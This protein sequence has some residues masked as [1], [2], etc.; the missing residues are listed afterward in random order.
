MRSQTTAR[1][2]CWGGI[3]AFLL[4]GECLWAQQREPFL[5]LPFENGAQ[6]V[7]YHWVGEAFSLLLSELLEAA[8]EEVISTEDRQ[9]LYAQLQLPEG[10]VLTRASALK[11]AERLGAS[12]L[13]VGTY[14]VT[15]SRG[16]ER[17]AV[18][19]RVIHVREARMVTN[20][21]TLGAPLQELSSLM[22]T[23]AGEVRGARLSGSH[24][25]LAHLVTA[26]PVAALEYYVKAQMATDPQVKMRLLQRAERQGASAYPPLL[27]ELG[28]AHLDHGQYAE[29]APYFRRL[30]PESHL[31]KE[32]QFYLGICALRQK[33][34]ARAQQIYQ[35]LARLW[36]RPEVWNN[37][38]VVELERGQVDAALRD[39]LR[40]LEHTDSDPDVL[41]N[42]G[43]ALWR[44]GDFEGAV[45]PLQ[46][47]VRRQPTDAE[48]QY[49]LGRSLRQLGR[50]EEA[51]KA[52]AVARQSLPALAEWEKAAVPPLLPRLKMR[53]SRRAEGGPSSSARAHPVAA[54][55][56]AQ[57]LIE[58]GRVEEALAA[59]D[60]L[61]KRAPDLAEAHLLKARV[62]VQRG[63]WREALDAAQA[64]AFWDPQLVAAH[65][66]IARIYLSVGERERARASIRKALALD[67]NNPEGRELAQSMEKAQGKP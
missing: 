25:E 64:A 32:A 9:A 45:K 26:L 43:Y 44:R 29:A 40:A 4:L 36:P 18:A 14:R 31:Y 10:M 21:M 7:E 3:L 52:L 65:L 35:E 60:A 58:S 37:L 56:E 12:R 30:A 53:I 5:V 38:A 57:A 33:E 23:L 15:G 63:N 62:Y 51:Q 6:E 55:R 48:A 13:L 16:H 24:P 59:L 41:F 34:S 54:V 67:P 27:L 11:V 61:L 20:E 2:W 42:Y 28:R 22:V 1:R 19:V 46:Q 8:G 47:L 50:P 17:I 49:L 39:L 66:L